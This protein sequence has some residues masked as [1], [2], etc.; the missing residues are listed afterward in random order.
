MIEIQNY[1]ANL[2]NGPEANHIKCADTSKDMH[3]DLF[4]TAQRQATGN[5]T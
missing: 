2:N 4:Q 3:L 1:F 5:I